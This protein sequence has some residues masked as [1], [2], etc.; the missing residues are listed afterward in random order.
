ML[1]GNAY[2]GHVTLEGT[3]N[4]READMPKTMQAAGPEMSGLGN[5]VQ[6]LEYL[7]NKHKALG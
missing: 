4:G 7:L 1:A 6:L 5:V 2:R 3:V